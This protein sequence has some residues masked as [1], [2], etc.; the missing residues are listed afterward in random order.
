MSSSDKFKFLY[1]MTLIDDMG[2][3]FSDI[4]SGNIN[5]DII[6]DNLSVSEKINFT[7][8]DGI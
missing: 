4:I 3:S 6:S 1:S 7:Y 5:N 8:S 2:V